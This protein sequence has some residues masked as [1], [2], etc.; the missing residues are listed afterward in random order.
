MRRNRLTHYL[1]RITNG[2]EPELSSAFSVCE[3]IDQG[4][5]PWQEDVRAAY[6]ALR[7]VQVRLAGYKHRASLDERNLADVANKG[8]TSSIALLERH[9][10]ENGYEL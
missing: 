2:R 9:A 3:T 5:I 8:L 6:S 4:G 7:S 1:S 10:S